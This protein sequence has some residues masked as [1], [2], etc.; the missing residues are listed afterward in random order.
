LADGCQDKRVEIPKL[1]PKWYT[2]RREG[3]MAKKSA[4]IIEIRKM[5]G[6]TGLVIIEQVEAEPSR[7]LRE[8]FDTLEGKR[9]EPYV[10]HLLSNIV[11]ITLLAV[12]AR[13]N[14]W[15]EIAEFARMKE[16]WLRGFLVL[17][18][19]IPS[20]DTIQR[21]MS[22]IDGGRGYCRAF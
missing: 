11:M 7:E 3:V 8:C 18:H 6:K 10:E 16:G 15:N 19:G 9:F 13:A 1:G 4:K 17:P 20:R 21:V 12:M 2:L 22:M 14:E 5:M